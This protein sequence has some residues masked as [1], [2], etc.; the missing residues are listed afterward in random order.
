[1][2]LVQVVAP[3]VMRAE[4]RLDDETVIDGELVDLPG[5]MIGSAKVLVAGFSGD[6]SV[7]GQ[8]LEP[9]GDVVVYGANGQELERRRLAQG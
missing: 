4:I 7:E 6:M 8:H 5:E 3:T 9:N 1:M 2:L